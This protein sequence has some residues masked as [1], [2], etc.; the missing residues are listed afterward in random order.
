VTGHTGFKG[1]WLALWLARLGAEVTGLA[2]GT[3]TARSL[4]EVARVGEAVAAE[5][6]DVRDLGAV[7]AA[8]ARAR[9]EVVVHMAAQA[10]VRRSYE[11]PV[12][13]FETNV[14]GTVNVLDAARRSEGVRAVVVVTTDKVYA[15]D[16][17]GRPF[18]EE[19]PLGGHDPYSSSK[20]AAEIAT[21]AY[22]DWNPDGPRVA[23]ARAGNV[24]G[25]GDWAP[26]RLVPDV[27]A[28]AVEGR[29]V[30]IRNPGAVRPWQHVLAPLHGYLL[31]AERLHGSADVAGAFNFGPDDD[32]ARPVADVVARLAQLWPGGID[33]QA[34]PDDGPHEAAALR[35]DST[36]AREQLGWQPRWDLDAALRSIAAWHLAYGA[37]A[38]MRAVTLD[39]IAAYE[40]GRSPEAPRS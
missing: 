36:R 23:T 35:L 20:A 8:L 15:N 31:L 2:S 40:E 33:W 13:T 34:Q 28:A 30:A 29:S 25:G 27:V 12:A 5:S 26:D 17:R 4:H 11:Q 18:S 39:Q 24:I 37:G 32:D 38:D 7:E 10:I 1:S 16:G 14:L 9:P 3:P 6:G 21:A 22:R 19:A